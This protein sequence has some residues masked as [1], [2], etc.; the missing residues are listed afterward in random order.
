MKGTDAG[1]TIVGCDL[2]VAPF[3]RGAVLSLTLTKPSADPPVPP[4]ARSFVNGTLSKGESL[5]EDSMSEHDPDGGIA[6]HRMS[7]DNTGRDRWSTRVCRATRDD[8]VCGYS[9]RWCWKTPSQPGRQPVV[10]SLPHAISCVV[11]RSAC[12]E[13]APSGARRAIVHSLRVCG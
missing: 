8:A 2:F 9:S 6:S 3:P 4:R 12:D 5:K 10:A 11:R 13:S 1:D 7:T